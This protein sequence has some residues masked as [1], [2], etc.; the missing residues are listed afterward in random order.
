M[1]GPQST[2]MLLGRPEWV[3]YARLCNAPNA[4][5]ARGLKVSKEEIAGLVAAVRKFVTVDEVAETAEY[6][7]LMHELV[8]QVDE[9]RG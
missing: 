1:R 7:R 9:V 3:E 8:E 4:T 5:V 2:G 6:L